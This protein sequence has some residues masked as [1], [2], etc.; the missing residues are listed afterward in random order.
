MRRFYWFD[1]RPNYGDL[2]SRYLLQWL[3]VP[4][5]HAKNP[6]QANAFMVGSVARHARPKDEVFGSGFIDSSDFVCPTAAYH[7]VRGPFS[8]DKVL[9][10]GG[11]CP[12]V[13]GDPALLL[14]RVWPK[15]EPKH[16]VGIVPHYV[17]YEW[18]A[19]EFPDYPVIN[20]R[21]VDCEKTTR[22][23]TECRAIVSSSLHGIIVA[24]AYGIPAAWVPMSNKLCGDG[25][26][27]KDHYASVGLTAEHSTF[28]QP[29]YTSGN[30]ND[31]EILRI[32][33]CQLTH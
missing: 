3:S 6:R 27:F 30:Y 23:I 19:T 31:S 26:K 1:K 9:S 11:K 20:V 28:E 10:V 29:I 16:D 21:E 12:D 5:I 25:I 32:L 18:A 24:H 13:Y 22:Q 17:D 7:W 14:P 15:A 2:L 4:F 8:R 33:K